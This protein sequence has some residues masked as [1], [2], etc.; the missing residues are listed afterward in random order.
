MASWIIYCKITK[1]MT[2]LHTIDGNKAVL[3]NYARD[4]IKENQEHIIDKHQNSL[5]SI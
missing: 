5:I 4:L 1:R 3:A 2:Y